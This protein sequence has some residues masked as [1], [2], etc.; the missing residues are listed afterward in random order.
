M[1][2]LG[3]EDYA[4]PGPGADGQKRP[5][6]PHSRFQARLTPS[7]RIQRTEEHLSMSISIKLTDIIQ[8]AD[9]KECKVHLACANQDGVH[10]LTECVADRANWVGGNEWR[11]DKNA[12][13]RCAG[14]FPAH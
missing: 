14:I 3:S 6:V 5:L 2:M 8:I 10:L 7:V 12:R 4:E 13:R 11:G 9:P 1:P